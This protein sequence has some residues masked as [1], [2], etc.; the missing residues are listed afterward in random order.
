[1]FTAPNYVPYRSAAQTDARPAQPPRRKFPLPAECPIQL[2][3]YAFDQEYEML[4]GSFPPAPRNTKSNDAAFG[5]GDANAILTGYS[6][7]S[8]SLAGLGKFS[9][10]F[11]IVP[12]AWDDFKEISY[13]FPGF[14]GLAGSSIARNV[15]TDDVQIRLHYDYFLVDPGAIAA[16]VLDSGGGAVTV[17][18]SLAAIPIIP[19]GNFVAV[20]SGAAVPSIRVSSLVKKGG[21]TVGGLAYD[22]TLPDREFYQKWIANAIA[23]GWAATAWDGASGVGYTAGTASTIGQFVIKE[24]QIQPYAGNIIAR[25][26]AYA[27]A[28]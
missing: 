2:A 19:K 12:A 11:S 20:Q 14:P 7:P 5:L 16:G 9:A 26:T 17:V 15:F 3:A 22:E 8:P 24:S 13:T 10:Q 25:V 23:S 1:M 4:L 6:Q 28:K 21:D 27:L 18:S